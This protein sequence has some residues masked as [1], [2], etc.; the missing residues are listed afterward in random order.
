MMAGVGSGQ[1]RDEAL[2]AGGEA[3]RLRGQRIEAGAGQT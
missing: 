1:L 2:D 3:F